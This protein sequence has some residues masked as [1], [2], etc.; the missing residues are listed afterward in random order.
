MIGSNPCRKLRTTF[1]DAPERPHADTDEVDTI[2][3]R[4][5]PGNGLLVQTAAHTGMRW[6]EL[7]RLQWARVHLDHDIPHIVIDAKDRALHEIN[8][9]LEL[10]PPKT[11]SSARLVHL[12]PF[13]ADE[14]RQ[15][16]HRAPN[17]RFVFTGP[18]RTLHRRSN[19]RRRAWLPALTGNPHHGW[20]PLNQNLHF[21]DLRHTHETW[22]VKDDVPRV[23]RL[24]R[25]GHKRKDIND[26]YSHVTDRMVQ[27]ML[28]TLQ[29]RW[30][31]DGGRTWRDAT[32][33]EQDPPP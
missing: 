33:T 19:F 18:H 17:T 29:T 31:T 26:R 13:L 14:L 32:D 16:H 28:D 5:H 20:A 21:H 12:P 15:H 7:T 22:L 27:A 1:A 11:S 25:L 6:G 10:G 8:G 24:T 23:L 30:T 9:R 4:M 2:A 3:W